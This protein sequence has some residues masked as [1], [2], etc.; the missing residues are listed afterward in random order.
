MQQSNDSG[1]GPLVSGT[2]SPPTG[3][4]R[5]AWGVIILVALLIIGLHIASDS[6]EAG[7]DYRAKISHITERMEGQVIVGAKTLGLRAAVESSLRSFEVGSV[8][9][10]IRGVV[11]IGEVNGSD[12]AQAALL[13][14]EVQMDEAGVEPDPEQAR[15]M[16]LLG[17]VYAAPPSEDS[18]P[19]ALDP[20]EQD[21]LVGQLGW[22]GDIALH[23]SGRGATSERSR[24]VSKARVVMIGLGVLMLL[25]LTGFVV[26]LVLLVVLIVLACQGRLRHGMG[27]ASRQDG[28]L[29]EA[30]AVWLVLFL[31]VQ[32]LLGLLYEWIPQLQAIQLLLTGVAQG[33]TAGVVLWPVLRGD[34]W[35]RVRRAIGL[36]TG[37]EG[38]GSWWREIGWGLCGYLML[39]PLLLVGVLLVAVTQWAV[40]ASPSGTDFSRSA[41]PAHP[42]LLY[43]SDGSLWTILQVYFVAAVVAPFLEEIV[44]RGVLY[45]QLRTATHRWGL[46]GSMACSLLVVSLVFA[47]IHPQGLMA[48]PALATIA[49]GLGVMR[50]WR[51]SL[52]APMVMHGCSNAVVITMMVVVTR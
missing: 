31:L 27:T 47:A 38:R 41:D 49:V 17:R 39:L 37:P 4:P 18:V 21:A 24:W 20:G 30:F 51:G 6:T 33:L 35:S 15:M 19:G 28:L 22:F 42:I 36:T 14:L 52:L 12:A 40:T 34:R 45:R 26:G 11:L 25:L 16:E 13:R 3:F 50:E 29:A 1:T 46:F 43:V 10:R 5:L 8:G 9:R 2:A 23:P 44:F 32:Y 7:R 48:V